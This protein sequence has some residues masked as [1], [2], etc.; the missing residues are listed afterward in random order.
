MPTVAQ[1]RPLAV[2]VSGTL[3]LQPAP[4]AAEPGAWARHFEDIY[5]SASGDAAAI[6]WAD[7]RPNPALLSWLT[8]EAPCLVRPGASAVVVGC[9]LGDDARELADR[10]YDVTAFDVSPTAVEWA[11]RRHPEIAD[12]FIITDLLA[13]PAT[14]LRRADLVVEISTIQSMHPDLRAGAAQ[15]IASLGRPRGTIIAICRGRDESDPL[16]DQPPYPLTP[17]ELTGLFEAQGWRPV[18]P[19][20]DF[21]DDLDP[22]RRRLR[23]AFRK[24]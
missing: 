16:D 21:Y 2:E 23:A 17:R 6:P 1:S 18:R 4:A 19:V 7:G 3:T 14:L 20:D 8:V 11:R 9:G 5:Q 10:G 13:L 12:R 15:A 22:P 24:G